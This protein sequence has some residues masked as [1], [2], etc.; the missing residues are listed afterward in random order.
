MHAHASRRCLDGTSE[1]ETF[2]SSSTPSN[3]SD[4]FSL[5]FFL[6]RLSFFPKEACRSCRRRYLLDNRCCFL[7]STNRAR[8]GLLM[9]TLLTIQ[10]LS[11]LATT[12]TNLLGIF[13]FAT[14]YWSIVIYD[15]SKLRSEAQWLLIEESS[16]GD[17]RFVNH[18]TNITDPSESWSTVVLGMENNVVLYP[19]HKG[20]FRQCN[21]LTDHV[22]SRLKTAHC[23]LLKT[24]NNQYDD[25]LHGM[26]NPGRELIR[27]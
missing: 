14:D 22:R 25:V 10:V 20:V 11:I 8:V 17:I 16:S 15:L 6:S 24:M 27:K 3:T 21:Y 26:N 18:S 13:T 4:S 19:T 5:S 12:L 7:P 23:R 9:V 2:S 1:R